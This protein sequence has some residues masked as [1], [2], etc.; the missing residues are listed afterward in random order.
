M[1]LGV[2]RYARNDI[3]RDV[4]CLIAPPIYSFLYKLFE[5]EHAD[6]LQLIHIQVDPSDTPSDHIGDLEDTNTSQLSNIWDVEP[7]SSHSNEIN[8][9]PNTL[10]RRRNTTAQSDEE[11]ERIRYSQIGRKKEFCH[12]ERIDGRVQNVLQG[13]ELHTSVFND[14]EQKKIVEYVYSI[15]RT[16]Q[17][18]QL[19]ERTYS[20]PRKWMRGKGRVTI[21]FGC[22]HNYAVDRNGNPPGIVREEEVDPLPL[23]FKQMIKRMVRWH[24]LPPTCIPNSCVV[25]IYDEGD[26]IPPH[27]DH[28]DFLR[29]ICTVSFLTECNILFGS[30]LKVTGP[31]EFSGPVSIPLPVGSVLILNGNGA[32]IAKHCVPAVPAKR[33]SITFRKMDDSKLPYEFSPDPELMN[34]H[35]IRNLIMVWISADLLLHHKLNHPKRT[36]KASSHP[37]SPLPCSLRP[38]KSHPFFLV[39]LSNFKFLLF[40]FGQG[41]LSSSSSSHHPPLNFQHF[42]AIA[43]FPIKIQQSKHRFIKPPPL[44]PPPLDHNIILKYASLLLLLAAVVSRSSHMQFDKPYLSSPLQDFWCWRWNVMVPVLF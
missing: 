5:V 7:S 43:C 15:Q 27:I 32:N 12:L 39:W 16:G 42:I 23:L 13:L 34:R 8:Q 1:D 26:C 37:P 35:E 18:G 40:A 24:V 6:Q 2:R 19:R 28:H 44:P 33:I 14:E 20:E 31:G 30:N 29:P 9:E 10:R 25:N 38:H 11:E 21:Q 41:P 36:F 4:C 22:C 3:L 17:N